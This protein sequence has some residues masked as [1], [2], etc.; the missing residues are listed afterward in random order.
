MTPALP[1][2]AWALGLAGLIPQAVALLATFSEGDRYI[3][4]AAGYF[5][6]A[7]I[8]SFLG[9]LWCGASQ[10]RTTARPTGSTALLSHHRFSRSSAAFPG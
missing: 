4:L 10:S 3:G 9:G 1:R 8:F 7:L 6:A 5:Y 2:A